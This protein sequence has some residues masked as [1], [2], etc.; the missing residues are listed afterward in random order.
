M[1]KT[2]SM[3]AAALVCVAACAVPKPASLPRLEDNLE[4][5]QRLDKGESFGTA[6]VLSTDG[7]LLTC[8]HV[9]QGDPE[10]LSVVI[11]EDGK[12]P[13]IYPAK[14]I[15]ISQ[16]D[17]LAV[18]KIEYHFDHVAVLADPSEVHPLDRIYTAGYPFMLNRLVGEGIVRGLGRGG[19]PKHMNLGH[20]ALTDVMSSSGGSGS[21]IFLE[22]NGKLVGIFNASVGF[23]QSDDTPYFMLGSMVLIDQIR[24]FLDKAH[25]PYRSR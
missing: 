23:K 21:G 16:E 18:V 5:T 13:V 20:V 14:V 8:R 24:A 4:A 2:L 15:A 3:Y 17:D 10:E 1:R 22:R 19:W 25:V 6:V 12:P 7:Y 9:V 11:S